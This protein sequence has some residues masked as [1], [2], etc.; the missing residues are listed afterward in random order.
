MEPE[1]PQDR[2]LPYRF[3]EPSDGP[4]HQHNYRYVGGGEHVVR[5]CTECNKSW[6]LVVLESLI[7]HKTIYVWRAT[8]EEDKV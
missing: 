2:V 3:T 4:P 6:A 8:I 7:D 1:P 5:Y